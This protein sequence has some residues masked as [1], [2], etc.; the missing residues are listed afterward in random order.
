[1]MAKVKLTTQKTIISNNT[2]VL[3]T[4]I[5]QFIDNAKLKVAREFNDAQVKLCWLIGNRISTEILNSQKAQYGEQIIIQLANELSLRYGGGFSRSK[6][7]RM[8]QFARFFADLEIVAT[9]SQQ[10]SWSHF[11]LLVAIEDKLKRDFYAEMSRV[12]SWSVRQ[13]KAQIDGMLYERTAIS[14]QPEDIAKLEIA[15]LQ[16]Q[17]QLTPTMLFKDPYFLDFVGLDSS[18][19]ESDLENAIL[20]EV[21][22]F[23]QELGTDFCFVA[24]QKRM[25]TGRKDRYLDLLLYNRSL[26][27]LIAIEL[28]IGEFDPA[29]KGQMEWYLKWLDKNERK[30]WE[31]KPLGIILC[32]YRDEEDIAYLELGKSGIH[33]AQ[34]FTGL[35]PKAVLE[36]KLR[37]AINVARESYAKKEITELLDNKAKLDT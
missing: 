11:V 1:M 8:V 7:F 15:K 22:K 37:Q 10:L 32:A 23:L 33:V 16:K 5:S 2:Q 26:Q 18:Y 3:V 27:R 25:S 21:A 35:P 9:L 20:N 14:K 13:L 31:K 17:D 36:E 28:K 19:S 12:S 6:L 34:Y 29:Y 4:D 24:R 30:P